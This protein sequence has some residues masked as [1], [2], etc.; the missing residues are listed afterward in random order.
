MNPTVL[1][2]EDNPEMAENIVSILELANYNVLSALDGKSGIELA[3]KNHP[4]LILCDIMMP[5]LDGYGVLHILSKDSG[6]SGIPFIF[7]TAKADRDDVRLGMNLGADD[8]ITKPFDGFNLLKVVETRM[9]KNEQLRENLKNSQQ[10]DYKGLN[11]VRELKELQKFFQTRPVRTF[12]K[13]EFLFMEGQTPTD[14]YYINKGEVK[15]YKVNYDGKEFITGIYKEGDFL[16]YVPLLEDKPYNETAEALM[17]T[18][19]SMVPRQDFKSLIHSN[20][21]I[22]LEFIKILS[23]NLDEVGNRLLEL[24]YQS[25]RQRVAGALLK[26]H[27]HFSMPDKGSVI[28]IAR[29]DISSI[30]GTVIE[31]LNRTLA[32]FKEEGL[33]EINGEGIRILD[34]GKLERILHH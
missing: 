11:R 31:S 3:Y 21:D 33:I 29:R 28:T 26:I 6:T 14:L 13:K 4:D 16:G 32:D 22:S 24:A 9:K 10:D 30:V 17:E 1:V 19:V 8:Y 15:T 20:R 5:E 34:R 23:E 25:V 27:D 7:L 12:K 18:K 2:I